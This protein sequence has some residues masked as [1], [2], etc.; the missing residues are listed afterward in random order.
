MIIM[1]RERDARLFLR[2]REI[3]ILGL[4]GQCYTNA[5]ISK[6]IGMDERNLRNNIYLIQRIIN[7]HNR[8]H[9]I[10]YAQEHGYGAP[11][12]R[13]STEQEEDS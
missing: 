2:P 5:E 7:V 1:E 4:I 12:N 8:P 13:Y 11:E 10:L 3:E 9:L 6:I